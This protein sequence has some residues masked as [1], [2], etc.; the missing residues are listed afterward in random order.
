MEESVETNGTNIRG[1]VFTAIVAKQEESDTVQFQIQ[2]GVLVALVNGE[3]SDFSELKTQEFRNV[4]IY[5][6]GSSNTTFSAYFIN[7]RAYIKV[8]EVNGFIAALTVTV[9][10]QYRGLTRGLMGNYNG[11]D[12]DDLIPRGLNDS[13]PL[14]SSLQTIHKDFGL[15]CE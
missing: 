3:L 4:V 9:P 7:N 13:L 5:N 15:T 14:N 1:T 2:N 11:N 8:Q 10:S 6:S 12:T